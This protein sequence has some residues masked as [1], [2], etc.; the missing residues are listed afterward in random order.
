MTRGADR[1]VGPGA[2]SAAAAVRAVTFALVGSVLAAVGHHAVDGGQVPWRLVAALAVAQS[3][4]VRPLARRRPGLRTVVGCTLAAQGAMHLALGEVAGVT[5]TGTGHAGTGHLGAGHTAH[6]GHFA[7]ATGDGGPAWQHAAGAMT[8]AHVCAALLVAWLLHRAD[9]AVT[10][11]LLT[12]RT[13][14]A[15]AAAV[16]S[17]FLPGGG[18]AAAHEPPTVPLAGPCDGP[19][20]THTTTLEHTLVRRGPPGT[21]ARPARPLHPGAAP[22][23]RPVPPARSPPVPLSAKSTP[24]STKSTSTLTKFPSANLRRAG[25]AGAAAL[26]A[27]LALAGPAAAHAE[28]E[29]DKAQ[30]LAEN[31]TLTFV[32]EAESASGG[33]REVRVVLP[34]GIAPADVSLGKAP[35]GWSLKVTDDGYVVGGPALKTGVDAEYEVRVRQL[36]DVDEV[37]FKTVE[38]YSDGEISRWI[39]LPKD[40]QEAEQPAPLLKLKAAAP[41]ATPVAPSPSAT[42]TPSPTPSAAASSTATATADASTAAEAGEKKDDDGSSTGLLVGGAIAAVLVLGGGA[43]WLTKR[44]ASATGG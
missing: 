38:T 39:E 44:R 29:A 6:A 15:L 13:L 27:V 30:A 7:M 21:Y 31:V 3:A 40:G 14:R 19:T 12:G 25:L 41:G 35:K 8:A 24:P 42:P 36:P 20:G 9:A 28:V 23:P 26:T 1:A 16:L 18:P 22:E 32:S 33:F 37:A 4:V 2:G 11:V 5:R 43:W 17:R 34:E 10:A